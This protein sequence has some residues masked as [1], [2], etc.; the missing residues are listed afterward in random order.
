MYIWM[1]WSTITNIYGPRCA[2]E[3]FHLENEVA[4]QELVE[5]IAAGGSFTCRSL[6][7]LVIGIFVVCMEIP[8]WRKLTYASKVGEEKEGT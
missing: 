7:S 5:M 1:S 6:Y 4:V 3:L 2:A 8:R